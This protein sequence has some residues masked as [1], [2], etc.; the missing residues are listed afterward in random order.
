MSALPLQPQLR[1]VR[2]TR[3]Y[4]HLERAMRRDHALPATRWT[5][6]GGSNH[7][8]LALLLFMRDHPAAAARR[9]SIFR[10][11]IEP[12]LCPAHRFEQRDADLRAEIWSSRRLIVAEIEPGKSPRAAGAES[13]ATAAAEKL[14]EEIAEVARGLEASAGTAASARRLLLTGIA[15]PHL[16]LRYAVLPIT[17]ELVIFLALLRVTD[18]L[19]GLVDLLEFALRVLIVGIYVGMIF[20]R[21]LAEGRFDR[22]LRRAP[23]HAEGFVVVAEFHRGCSITRCARNNNQQLCY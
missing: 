9:A 4:R 8:R 21:E 5:R 1:A 3:R 20:A 17:A 16:F 23:I 22:G 14:R 11:E 12:P 6:L 18:Y 19:V 15:P 7:A 2:R 10:R 13:S